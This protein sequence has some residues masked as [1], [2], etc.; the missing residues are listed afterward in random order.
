MIQTDSHIEAETIL[1]FVRLVRLASE[2]QDYNHIFD[3]YFKVPK[4]IID[5][6]LKSLGDAHGKSAQLSEVLSGPDS[7]IRLNLTDMVLYI[8]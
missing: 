8:N 6:A 7:Y 4:Y 2:V 3:Q 1:D 5:L